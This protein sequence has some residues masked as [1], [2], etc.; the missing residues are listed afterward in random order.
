MKDLSLFQKTRAICLTFRNA[1]IPNI[2]EELKCFKL[3]VLQKQIYSY[4]RT[5]S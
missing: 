4:L 2:E 5:Q 3:K 1:L